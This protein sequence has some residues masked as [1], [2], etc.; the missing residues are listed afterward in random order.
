MACADGRIL[1]IV[2]LQ[3]ID[4]IHPETGRLYAEF[5]REPSLSAGIYRLPAGSTDPQ[6]PHTEDEL[7][8]V[9]SGR[10]QFQLETDHAPVEAGSVIF[11][12]AGAEHRFHSIEADLIILVVFAPAE[13]S[14]QPRE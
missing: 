10:G 7:Y 13:Y 9:I 14:L 3:H 5:L 6:Q 1:T 11:V 2:K 12:P 8:C 4:D